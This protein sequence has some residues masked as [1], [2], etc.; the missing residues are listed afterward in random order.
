[1]Q[2]IITNLKVIRCHTGC[3]WSRCSAG[4]MWSNFVV[5]VTTRAA[6]FWTVWSFVS[7]PS[8]IPYS[9]DCCSCRRLLL[10]ACTSVFTGSG[11]SK[12]LII[13]SWRSWN[14]HNRHS[15]AIFP[16]RCEIGRR[17]L[18]LINRKS[19][20]RFRLATKSTTLDDLERPKCH[21]CSNG[22]VFRSPPEK[23]EW[24]KTDA[25]SDAISF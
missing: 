25:I 10:N 5:P 2:V 17:L 7:R 16:K 9:I 18:W 24:I 1:L 23:F 19:H 21:S 3:Q 13:R 22:I 4:V 15:A 6:A 8:L 14:R 12:D 11:V 20:T